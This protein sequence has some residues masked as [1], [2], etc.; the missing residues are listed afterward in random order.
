LA[1]DKSLATAPEV[2]VLA[3]GLPFPSTP[4]MRQAAI[5]V[6][7]LDPGASIGKACLGTGAYAILVFIN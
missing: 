5:P 3:M 2:F 7:S 1:E 4:R 6:A